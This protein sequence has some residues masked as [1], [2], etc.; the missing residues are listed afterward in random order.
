M[1]YTLDG[2][3]LE[4]E[5]DEWWGPGFTEWTNVVKGRPLFRGHQQPHYPGALGYSPVQVR[6]ARPA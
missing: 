1:L 3:G 4:T 6:Q 5:N 2:A